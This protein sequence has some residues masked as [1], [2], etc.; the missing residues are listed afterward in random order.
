MKATGDEIFSVLLLER[1]GGDRRLALVVEGVEDC[2]LLD[3]HLDANTAKTIWSGSKTA[4]LEAAQLA[5]DAG[6]SWARF[7]IDTDLD[8]HLGIAHAAPNIVSTTN[9]DLLMDAI[10]SAPYLLHG[11]AISHGETSWL[12]ATFGTA[13]CAAGLNSRILEITTLTGTARLVDRRHRLGIRTTNLNYRT[14][15]PAGGLP[16]ATEWAMAQ[17]EPRSPSPENWRKMEAELTQ[18]TVCDFTLVRGHDLIAAL[19][20]L[21]RGDGANTNHQALAASLRVAVACDTF[22][23]LAVIQTLN[24]WADVHHGRRLFRCED[25]TSQVA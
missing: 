5:E 7:I 2:Q 1:S 24:H 12:H 17:L 8:V 10:D 16:S 11:V 6:L 25:T 9:Y 18:V 3:I 22:Q 14:A 15:P 13:N 19:A 4:V 21:L 20:A 23:K